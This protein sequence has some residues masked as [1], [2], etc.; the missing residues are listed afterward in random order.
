MTDVMIVDDHAVVRMGLKAVFALEGDMRV[1]ADVGTADEALD[2][3]RTGKIDV[4]I[5][6]LRLGA[7]MDGTELIRRIAGMGDRP[8][9]LVFSTFDSEEDVFRAI[10]AGAQGY[11]PKQSSGAE[12]AAAVRRVAAG[13]KCIPPQIAAKLRERSEKPVLSA[14]QLEIL[15]FLASGMANKEIAQKVFVC[16]DTVKTH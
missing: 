12:L 6:D 14:R 1:V 5:V 15:G 7:G 16:E 9:T 11:L 4:A 3:L 10:E 8:R 13:E 2:F